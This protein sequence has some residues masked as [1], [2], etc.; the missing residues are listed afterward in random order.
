VCDNNQIRYYLVQFLKSLGR[1]PTII[2]NHDYWYKS[3][4][5][6][7]KT[8]SF[9]VNWNRNIWFEV[10]ADLGLSFCKYG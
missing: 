1:E 10:V 7:E 5:R 3:P 2:R 9:K 8:A 6:A 4:F